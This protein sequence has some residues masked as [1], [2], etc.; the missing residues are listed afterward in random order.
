MERAGGEAS[1][2]DDAVASTD[3]GDDG[4]RGLPN[5]SER[6]NEASIT[7]ADEPGK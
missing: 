3:A 5:T 4:T 7:R 6:E 1:I 2:T